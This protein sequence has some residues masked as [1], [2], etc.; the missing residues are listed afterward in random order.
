[1]LVDIIKEDKQE[2]KSMTKRMVRSLEKISDVKAKKLN[3]IGRHHAEMEKYRR[4]EVRNKFEKNNKIMEIEEI[5]Y[6]L[7]SADFTFIPCW[8]ADKLNFLLH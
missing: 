2:T 8:I 1:M 7:M 5:K 6:S 4:L 3:E